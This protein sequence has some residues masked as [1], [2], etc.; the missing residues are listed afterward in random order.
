MESGLVEPEV[1][2]KALTDEAPATSPSVVAL[3]RPVAS[4]RLTSAV[5]SN[6]GA[7]SSFF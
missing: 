3:P 4:T 5:G 6:R 2:S 1:R 7:D